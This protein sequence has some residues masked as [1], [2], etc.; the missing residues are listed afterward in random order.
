MIG[1]SFVGMVD[2]PDF[3][4][5]ISGEIAN[6]ETCGDWLSTALSMTLYVPVSRLK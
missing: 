3:V 2:C 1:I 5:T 6:P 4:I